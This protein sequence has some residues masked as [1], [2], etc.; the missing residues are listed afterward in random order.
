M[1]GEFD[2]VNAAFSLRA[3]CSPGVMS[4]VEE[5]RFWWRKS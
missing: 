5:L 3:L 2:G 4:T 1:S